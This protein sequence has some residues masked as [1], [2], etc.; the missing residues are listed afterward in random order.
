GWG[1]LTRPEV[2]DFAWPTGAND[3]LGRHSVAYETSA[4]SCVE[5]QASSSSGSAARHSSVYF[6]D[7][8]S[9]RHVRLFKLPSL[10]AACSAIRIDAHGNVLFYQA[11]YEYDE[12]EIPIGV[13]LTE[14]RIRD[15]SYEPTGHTTTTRFLDAENVWRFT[16][17]SSK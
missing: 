15:G 11:R 6:I 17:Q 14:F 8:R 7:A 16:I 5:G 3:D 13:V 4:L 12:G 1:N 2:G 10:F 9:P